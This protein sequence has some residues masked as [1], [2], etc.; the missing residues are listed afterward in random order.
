MAQIESRASGLQDYI[1]HYK[2][3]GAIVSIAQFAES[4]TE[5]N[6]KEISAIV[7]AEDYNEIIG[8]ADLTKEAF[9]NLVDSRR[10]KTTD[11]SAMIKRY[12][13]RAQYT[14][15]GTIDMKW[16][17]TYSPKRVQGIWKGLHG[18][19]CGATIDISLGYLKELSRDDSL[20]GEFIP[21][22]TYWRHYYANEL[23]KICGFSS[24][25][26]KRVITG[27]SIR[28]RF[29]INKERLNKMMDNLCLTFDGKRG[30]NK[31]ILKSELKF[32][33]GILGMLYGI[34][35]HRL[36]KKKAD[37]NKYSIHHNV[38]ETLFATSFT[39]DKP[40]IL[41]NYYDPAQGIYG[42]QGIKDCEF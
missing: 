25:L 28:A 32:V 15:M 40:Y 37:A 4:P 12:Q 33:N 31:W 8:A 3:A 36:T 34:S 23:L 26:D 14:W 11:E 38:L 39:K 22:T 27:D 24:L 13:L 5:I 19:F 35:I 16:M 21:K 10:E 7:K 41:I 17:E 2:R 29:E 30:L 18:Y 6:H 9:I 1:D 20:N 42:P